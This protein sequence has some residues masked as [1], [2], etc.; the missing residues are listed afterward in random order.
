MRKYRNDI[1]LVV[2]VLLIA[3]IGIILFNSCSTKNDLKALVYYD[4]NLILEIELSENDEYIIKGEISDLRIIVIDNS[5]C[6][7]ESQCDDHVCINQGKIDK[8]GQTITCLPNKVYIKLVGS[9]EG[10]DSTIWV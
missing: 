7:S 6:I 2:S 1:I 8:S 5:I 4:E 9:N 3:I 10:V